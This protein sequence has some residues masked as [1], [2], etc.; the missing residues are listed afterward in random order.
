MTRRR[1]VSLERLDV[2]G[3]LLAQHTD[4]LLV[5]GLGNPKLACAGG[6]QMEGST[7][8]AIRRRQ[9]L[10]SRNSTKSR[11]SQA[12]SRIHNTLH[13]THTLECIGTH[14]TDTITLK[15]HGHHALECIGLLTALH[16]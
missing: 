5:C 7:V 8:K 6:R 3:T 10:C 15:P 11:T 13:V 2:V 9:Q 12:H 14:G 4:M 16:N 1:K